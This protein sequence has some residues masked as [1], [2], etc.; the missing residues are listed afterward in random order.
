MRSRTS[1]SQSS[2]ELLDVVLLHMIKIVLL[3]AFINVKLCRIPRWVISFN[4]CTCGGLISAKQIYLFT[5]VS[6]WRFI[7]LYPCCSHVAYLTVISSSI[8]RMQGLSA[9]ECALNAYTVP[10]LKEYLLFWAT[11]KRQ[12]PLV[13]WKFGCKQSQEQVPPLKCD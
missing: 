6:V 11:W 2:S 10:M 9:D 7:R 1:K 4:I 8:R 13:Y 5:A 12:T 3:S